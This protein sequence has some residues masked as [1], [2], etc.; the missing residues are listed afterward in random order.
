MRTFVIGIVGAGRIFEQHARAYAALGG[1]ARLLAVADVDPAQLRKATT[2]FFIPYAFEDHRAVLE[3]TDVDVVAVC[4]PPA[5]IGDRGR[6]LHESPI[7]TTFDLSRFGGGVGL[8]GGEG[9]RLADHDL[10][11]VRTFADRLMNLPPFTRVSE[12]FVRECARALRKVAECAAAMGERSGPHRMRS[13]EAG[14]VVED[15]KHG[16]FGVRSRER[17]RRPARM[18]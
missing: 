10:P 12:R 11:V 8:S 17:A 2:H 9:E 13:E 1:R 7:F 16:R 5:L 14:I 6:L 18:V 3:R 15:E 4:T